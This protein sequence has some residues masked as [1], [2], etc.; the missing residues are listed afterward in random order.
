MTVCFEQV[1]NLPYSKTPL[2]ESGCL[3]IFLGY[4]SM[5]PALHPCFSDPWRSPPALNSTSTTFSCLLFV[6]VSS[7]LIHF[8]WPLVTY[9]SLCSNYVT[10]R[11]PWHASGHQALL[12]QTL[13]REAEHF[14][15]GGYQFKHVPL[16]TYLA[17]LQPIYYD[18]G[19]VLIH[20]KPRIFLLVVK[21][22]IKTA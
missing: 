1:K 7:F 15:K 4:L 2:G 14:P 17:W 5:L 19:L 22:L 8:P 20:V 11:S 16:F 3:S 9:P 13:P 21:T 12:T 18:L 6:K 10:Y